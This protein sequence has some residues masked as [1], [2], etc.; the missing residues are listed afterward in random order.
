MGNVCAVCASKRQNIGYSELRESIPGS[1]VSDQDFDL[2]YSL[3]KIESVRNRGTSLN[4]SPSQLF[5]VVISGE[6][7]AH[8]SSPDVKNKSLLTTTFSRGET[9][10]F[11]NTKLEF[12]DCHHSSKVKL[13]FYSKNTPKS[14]THVIGMDYSAFENFLV[15]AR[16]NTHALRSFLSLTMTDLPQKSAFFK[17]IT[18]EQV[19]C[20]VN[21][22]HKF[23]L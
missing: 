1:L 6:V 15:N 3:C 10:H 7:H 17:T 4:P 2:Y 14:D 8:L 16:N 12:D 22:S 5:Y 23:K 11:F 9:I 21:I 18:P 20:L 19:N 13:T